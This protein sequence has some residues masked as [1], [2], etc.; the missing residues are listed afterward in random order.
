MVYVIAVILAILLALLCIV[1][2]GCLSLDNQRLVC[3]NNLLGLVEDLFQDLV[4]HHSAG[5]E[6]IYAGAWLSTH[7]WLPSHTQRVI[8]ATVQR[9]KSICENFAKR[10]GVAVSGILD[11]KTSFRAISGSSNF[12]GVVRRI[13]IYLA[14]GCRIKIGFREPGTG[15]LIRKILGICEQAQIAR[16]L[17]A[18]RP[19]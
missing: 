1:A 3:L 15:S 11:K 14:H 9:L 19:E 17:K 12:K 7:Q 16:N 6:G 2:V 10:C 18:E 4:S 8:Q 5:C 13:S